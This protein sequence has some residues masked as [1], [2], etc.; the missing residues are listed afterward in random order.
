MANCSSVEGQLGLESS[1]GRVYRRCGCR[2]KESG[3]QLWRCPR[4]AGPDHGRWYFAVQV[5]GPDGRRQRVR[6]GGF[7]TR[8]AAERAAWEVLQ[9]PGPRA[10]GRMWTVRRWLEFWLSDA[11]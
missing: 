4:L 11:E 6:K 9:L 5:T 7:V 1:A 3:R 2:N 10:V 8:A